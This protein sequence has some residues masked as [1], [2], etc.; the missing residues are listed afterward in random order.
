MKIL[1]KIWLTSWMLLIPAISLAKTDSAKNL[2]QRVQ[3][4]ESQVQALQDSQA[5]LTDDFLRRTY[6]GAY[7]NFRYIDAQ[8]ENNHFD[9]NRF[10]LVLNSRFHDRLRA[11]VDIKFQQAAGIAAD[12]WQNQV[13][14]N[15]N[16]SGIVSVFESY[17]DFILAK[18]IN[19]RAGIFLVPIAEYNR[20]PYMVN[21]EFADDPMESY[22]YSDVGAEL[23]G[24]ASL[25]DQ[26]KL[27]YE[28]GAVQGLTSQTTGFFPSYAQDNN[29]A[30]SVFGRLNFTFF[31][32]AWLN[33]AGYYG[34]FS[35]NNNSMYIVDSYVKLAPTNINVLNH[36]ELFAEGIYLDWQN[37]GT[38]LA[39]DRV[40][41]INSYFVFKFWPEILNRTFL[42]K[43]FDD[44]QFT[45]AF[46]YFRVDAKQYNPQIFNNASDNK[47][48]FA[49]GYRPISNFVLHLQY[50]INK[51]NSLNFRG[52][53]NVFMINMAYNF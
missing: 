42:G 33:L 39:L 17:V 38:P 12:N 37:D 9:G 32:Q 36:F 47:Y 19:F 10:D 48:A 5:S 7:A 43:R 51:G 1:T 20:N 23:F 28:L 46:R 3:E 31:N 24:E 45:L 4:L 27:Y 53:N 15:N 30:K 52:D 14:S 16:R 13:I 49:F 8:G 18:W 6:I 22:E 21:K 25:S 2:E 50:E 29:K 44:P 35:A 26:I 34:D 11:Y 40:Y 41:L